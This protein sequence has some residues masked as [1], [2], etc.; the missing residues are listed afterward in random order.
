MIDPTFKPTRVQTWSFTVQREIASSAVFS[1]AYVGSGARHVKGS[2]D[3]NF[4]VSVTSPTT[5]GCLQ[6]GQSIPAGGFD[7]DPCLNTA[8][9]SSNITR[10][11]SG[12]GPI[13]L[14]FTGGTSNYHSLQTG[15]QY[16][17]GRGLTLNA[18]YTFGK[19]LADVATR[20]FDGRNTGA[21]AQDPRRFKA[22][23]GPPGWD[24]THI[25]TAGYVWEMPFFRGAT[26][27][28]QKALGNWTLSGIT[29]IQSGFALSPT[30]STGTVGL[31]SRP[32][33]VGDLSYPKRLDQW[34]NTQAFA[35]PAYGFFGN[36]GTGLIRGPGEH[37]WNTAL[38]KDFRFTER[39]KLQ[40]RAE[41]FNI[42]NH[43]NFDAVST[44][45]GSGDYG[46]VTRAMEP[47]IMEFALRFSF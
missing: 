17:P 46:Q 31:A 13:N 10:P 37:T 41:A 8:K 39:I 23:Y 29:V 9:V 28:V 16:R 42:W 18:A 47:R 11:Y 6:P 35:P 21:G 30:L 26:N 43:P 34:F 36:A 7:F 20:S 24:R 22:D 3:I 14:N 19:A 12:W 27:V 5:A 38:F 25:F 45:V 44:G 2:R 32:N 40:F 1:V 33:V 15:F 4:P